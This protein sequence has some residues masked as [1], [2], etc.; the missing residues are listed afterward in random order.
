MADNEKVLS[1]VQ[2]DRR[3]FVKRILVGAAFAAPVLATFSIDAL[4]VR[5]AHAQGPNGPPSPSPEPS[6]LLLMG[7]GA[8]GLGIAAYRRSQRN[9]NEAAK[10]EASE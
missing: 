3:G 9:K 2:A 10:P 7:T 6:T 4:T 5:S 1:A 8:V